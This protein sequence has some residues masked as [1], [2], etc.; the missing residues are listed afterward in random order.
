M[1]IAAGMIKQLPSNANV[2]KIALLKIL[3]S[4]STGYFK[5]VEDEDNKRRY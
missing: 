5:T 1:Y 2:N 4:L 3:V